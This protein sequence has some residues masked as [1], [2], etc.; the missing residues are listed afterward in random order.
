[1][2]TGFVAG[3]DHLFTQNN[4]SFGQSLDLPT[5][6]YMPP[7]NTDQSNQTTGANVLVTQTPLPI[8]IGGVVYSDP[9]LNNHQDAGEHG[10]AGVTVTLSQFNGSQYVSTGQTTTTDANG[11]YLFQWELPGS[12]QVSE[13]VPANYFAVGATAGTVNG[14]TDGAVVGR[15]AVSQISV[16][17]GEDSV[18]N[19]FALAQAGSLSGY[20]YHDTNNDGIRQSGEQGLGGVTVVVTPVSTLDGSTTPIQ[21]VTGV[22]GSW[23]APGLAPGQYTVTETTQPAGYLDGKVTAGSLGGDVAPVGDQITNVSILGGQAGVEYDF[24]KRLPA[25]LSGNVSDCLTGT[26]LSGVSVQLLDS[27]G[28]VLQSTTT[29]AQGNYQFNGLT[30]GATYGVSETLP[31]GYIHNDEVVGSVGGAIAANASIIQIAL[32]DGT[33]RDRLQLLRRPAGK[34][35]RK[36]QRLPRGHGAVGRDGPIAQ[37]A[38]QHPL[39]H[40]DRRERQLQLR[41][42]DA[43]QD[44]WRERNSPHGLHPQR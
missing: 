35:L 26:A 34:H 31:T 22:D 7:S 23:S 32:G 20:V 14:S 33:S 10:L 30:P 24:G 12:Y 18:H 6:N 37:R 11:A 17:G 9:N 8:S 16:L 36:C 29:N 43:G 28:N 44:L 13:T 42:F 15:T 40:H 39:D 27:Q 38:R 5:Q 25:S 41:E 1:M 2:N 19:D 3:F 21:I 4:T